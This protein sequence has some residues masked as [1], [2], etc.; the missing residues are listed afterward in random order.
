MFFSDYVKAKNKLIS[1]KSKAIKDN[2]FLCS[3][4]FHKINIEELKLEVSKLLLEDISKKVQDILE[5][6]K[7]KLIAYNAN[8]GKC[9]TIEACKGKIDSSKCQKLNQDK[10]VQ[11]VKQFPKNTGSHLPHWAYRQ[12]KVWF[13]IM[14]KPSDERSKEEK[15]TLDDFEFKYPGK[16]NRKNKKKEQK[17][18][19]KAQKAKKDEEEKKKGESKPPS[20]VENP[21]PPP[22]YHYP[23]GHGYYDGPNH[24]G[25]PP[26]PD[27][28]VCRSGYDNQS[29]HYHPS[30]FSCGRRGYHGYQN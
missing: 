14:S 27:S 13:N 2:H 16:D 20:S 24:W 17:E 9:K 22:P 12:V 11:F 5:N 10:K 8:L 25:Q 19:F 3:M 26:M 18:S 28:Y 4:L 15:K 6:I 23:Q 30:G 29:Q 21:P 1:L 7:K